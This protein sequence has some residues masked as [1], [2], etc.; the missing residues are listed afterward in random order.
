MK[1]KVLILTKEAIE[2][3]I[4][5]LSYE[6]LEDN[7]EEKEIVFVGIKENGLV[8]AEK[9]I[10]YITFKIFQKNSIFIFSSNKFTSIIF[11]H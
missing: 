5:R 7:Y 11:Y 3:K 6:I 8:F 10:N 4:K 1:N 2:Q 9:I